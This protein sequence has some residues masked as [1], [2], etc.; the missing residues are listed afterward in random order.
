MAKSRLI[1]ELMK[2]GISPGRGGKS[3]TVIPGEKVTGP[4]Q[5]MA[6]KKRK[7]KRDVA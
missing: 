2:D 5:P 1:S 3:K 6:Q 4:K 7:V